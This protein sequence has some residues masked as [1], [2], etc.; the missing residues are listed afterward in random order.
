VA[1]QSVGTVSIFAALLGRGLHSSTIQLNVSAFCELGGAFM[2]CV[3]GVR[4]HC[5]VSRVYFVSETA[6][7]ELKSG[8]V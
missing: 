4:G 7:V 1:V 8:R 5:G 3:R 6:H 2:D